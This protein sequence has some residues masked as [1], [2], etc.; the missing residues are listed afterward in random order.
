MPVSCNFKSNVKG[1]C[2][3]CEQIVEHL[4]GSLFNIYYVAT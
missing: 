4:K 1:K 2:Y 3:M